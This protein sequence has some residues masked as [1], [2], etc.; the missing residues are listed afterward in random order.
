[1]CKP[2]SIFIIL[3]VSLLYACSDSPSDN[4]TEETIPKTFSYFIDSSVENLHYSSASYSGKTGGQGEFEY[5]AGE[6]T[7]FSFAGFVL[8]QIEMQSNQAVV[9]PLEILNANDTND[10]GVKNLLVFLQSL[11][12]D[13]DPNNGITL[14]DTE[15]DPDSVPDLSVLD[16]SDTNFQTNLLSQLQTSNS[17]PFNRSTLVSETD[18]VAHFEETL[19]LLNA[20]PNL[21]AGRWVMRSPDGAATALYTLDYN[22]SFEVEEYNNCNG[23]Q[24]NGDTWTAS[25]NA[26]QQNCSTTETLSGQWSLSN[27]TLTMTADTLTIGNQPQPVTVSDTCTIISSKIYE[28]RAVCEFTGGDGTE[29]ILF[30]RLLSGFSNAQ[31][32]TTYTEFSLSNNSYSQQTFGADQTS[33]GYQVF[34]N[35]SPLSNPG[36]TGV[37]NSWSTSSSQLSINITDD[38]SP[39]QTFNATF[40]YVNHVEG[41]W[42]TTFTDNNQTSPAVLAPEFK[43]ITLDSLFGQA[44]YGIYN[45][46]TGQ[47]KS[48]YYVDTVIDMLREYSSESGDVYDCTYSF[49][50]AGPDLSLPTADDYNY[51]LNTS[52]AL[53]ITTS[54]GQNYKSC[55]PLRTDK[56]QYHTLTTMACY[57]DG[58]T[59]FELEIWRTL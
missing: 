51:I 17:S 54:G 18:A 41:A 30:Q 26:M 56:Y 25:I 6:T 49:P 38:D 28:T 21:G 40:N 14:G 48:V 45:A 9:T 5:N 15:S 19:A 43:K 8:G 47:C 23:T 3:I 37:F 29:Q 11:D 59:A 50:I 2:S 1:M 20:A 55:W 58:G 7:T 31:I 32:N 44:I 24:E 16:L 13:Q 27:K 52:G 33:G 42:E 10:Q 12:I 39:P 57:A 35:G 34:A 46:V 53:V 4:D 22:G 36:D